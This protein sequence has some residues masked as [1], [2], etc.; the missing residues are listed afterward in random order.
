MKRMMTLLVMA[1][2]MF[3]GNAFAATTADLTVSATVVG[4]C[5]ITG[6]T[7]AFGSIDNFQAADATASSAGVTVTCAAGIDYE[8]TDDGGVL[9]TYEMTSPSGNLAYSLAY[10]ALGTGT[11]AVVPL[12]IAGTVAVADLQAAAPDTYGDTV[13]LTIAPAP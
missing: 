8:V 13:V 7:L 2:V 12:A 9:T 1:L 3:T 4:S 10:T 6:G 11:G 5:A